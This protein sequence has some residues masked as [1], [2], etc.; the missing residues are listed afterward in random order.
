MKLFHFMALATLVA[1]MA[2]SA[3]AAEPT[4]QD[5]LTNL[6][7]PTGVAIQPGTGAIFIA[8]SGALRVLRFDAK[9]QKSETVINEFPKD[10]YGK[11]PKYDIG[12]LGLAFLDQN[13]LVVGDGGLPDGSELVR[14]YTVPAPGQ[15]INADHM[16]QKLG[17]IAPGEDSQKGEGNFYAVA[18]GAGGIYVTSN[19]D[20]TKGWI[21]KADRT[22][23]GLGKLTPFIKT[24]VATNVDAPVGITTN[25][26][27]NL[28]VGQMGE[29]NVPKDSLLTIYD[30]KSGSMLAN[31]E[32]GLYDIAGVAFS[33]KTGKLYAVD[34]A[35][36]DTTQGGLFRLDMT[37]A[38]GKM[39]VKATKIVS[40]DKPSSLAF[41]PDG[42]IYVTLLGTAKEGAPADTRPGKLVTVVGEE[43]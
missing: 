2:P 6:L 34:F 20:D 16:K 26:E 8:D 21:L 28:V 22:P 37:N 43:L 19:G 41:G 17:P 4:T 27:G 36:M 9:S 5:V 12:P 13:T 35:W 15:K 29:I 24:K 18:V 33:P 42:K 40:L 32:T 7:N 3:R 14:V 31:A 39:T 23:Q 1:L 10:V 30:P 38:G 25:K 11:G